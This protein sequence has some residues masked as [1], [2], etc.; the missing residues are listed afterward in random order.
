MSR[1]RALPGPIRTPFFPIS[2]VLTNP[3]R[4]GYPVL[5]GSGVCLQTGWF[6]GAR[7]R[8][9]AAPEGRNRTNAMYLIQPAW[10]L[11]IAFVPGE[12]FMIWVLWKFLRDGDR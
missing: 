6:S 2:L 9:E 11:L 8:A 7:R 1:R 10:I 12:A 5:T 3:L 4:P